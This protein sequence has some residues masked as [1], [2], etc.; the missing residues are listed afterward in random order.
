MNWRFGK[1][2]LVGILT[3]AMICSMGFTPLMANAA[4]GD[5]EGDVALQAGSSFVE[6]DESKY[7]NSRDLLDLQNS[8]TLEAGISQSG[9]GWTWSGNTLNFTGNA[10]IDGNLTL[11]SGIA[12]EIVTDQASSIN[13]YIDFSP[14]AR[15]DL[16]I[17]GLGLL[18]ITGWVQTNGSGG[19]I[20]VDKGQLNTGGAISAGS[21]GGANGTVAI[22]NSSQVNIGGIYTDTVKINDSKVD[23]TAVSC[24]IRALEGGVTISGKSEVIAG[25]DYAAYVIDGKFEIDK[26][27]TLKSNAAMAAVCVVDKSSTKTASQVLQIPAS[28]LNGRIE[29]ASVT[30]SDPNFP[31]TFWS[32]VPIGGTLTVS[33][34][35]NEPVTL[36]G[37]VGPMT[38]TRPFVIKASAGSGGTIS[39]SGEIQ[40]IPGD[41]QTF[42]AAANP[43]YR[44]EHILID[45]EIRVNGTESN[46]SDQP[47]TIENLNADHTITVSFLPLSPAESFVIT[48]SAGTGGTITPSGAV[49]V[50]KGQNQAFA[51]TA[52]E[53]YKTSKVLVDGREV[54]LPSGGN[55][56]FQAVSTNH[57]IE[58]RFEKLPQDTAVITASAGIGGT[59]SPSGAVTVTKG[60]NQ[61]FTITAEP[62]YNIL[63]IMV[64]GKQA[65]LEDGNTY[66]FRAVNSSHTIT[67]AFQKVEGSGGTA[68]KSAQTGDTNSLIVWAALLVLALSS[69]A[70]TLA[71]QK[72]RGKKKR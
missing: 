15:C 12:V 38:L 55:Y 20:T 52:D 33:D 11:P 63:N 41:S 5:V 1:K 16:T 31:Y 13:G 51:I 59:I 29:A 40:V 46:I 49:N 14:G 61:A 32:Y 30:S 44:I 35:N 39:P 28:M 17:T 66:T 6:M 23:I 47:I 24:A 57:T 37:A 50:P 25:C 56:T 68:S 19:A 45:G 69:A 71:V 54:P 10:L 22:Q 26:D 53:G 70:V 4:Q 65:V 48:A 72:R 9:A 2:P 8:L 60:Q 64:D 34:V 3:L 43:G 42:I 62:G 36:Q 27:S 21:S 67:A 18:T 7:A 58:A